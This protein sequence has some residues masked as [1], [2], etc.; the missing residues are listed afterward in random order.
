MD[1]PSSSIICLLNYQPT[2]TSNNDNTHN[3]ISVIIVDSRDPPPSNTNYCNGIIQETAPV[4]SAI[5]RRALVR[6]L[7]ANSHLPVT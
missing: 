2:T 3:N 4:G 6:N 1:G 5:I 7:D